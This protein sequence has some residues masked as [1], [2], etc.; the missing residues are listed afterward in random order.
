LR[1]T[2][3][4]AAERGEM[5]YRDKFIVKPGDKVHLARID[6]SYTGEHKSHETA[7][8]YPSSG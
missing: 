8:Q 2:R 1:V 3:P 7:A 5:D 6:P 4:T